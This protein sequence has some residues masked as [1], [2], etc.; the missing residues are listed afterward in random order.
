MPSFPVSGLQEG[1]FCLAVRNSRMELY[2]LTSVMKTMERNF[3]LQWNF[4]KNFSLPFLCCWKPSFL[5]RQF[6]LRLIAAEHNGIC[7]V[8]SSHPEIVD[9]ESVTLTG[10]V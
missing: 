7:S 3:K 6:N 9:Q 8:F 1:M 4:K 2:R 10:K 5:K